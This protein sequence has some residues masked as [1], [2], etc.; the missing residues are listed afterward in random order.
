MSMAVRSPTSLPRRSGG[1][2][3]ARLPRTSIH[4]TK[5][6]R[7]RTAH[8]AGRDRQH[9]RSRRGRR[10]RKWP[11]LDRLT[12]PHNVITAAGAHGAHRNPHGADRHHSGRGRKGSREAAGGHTILATGGRSFTPAFRSKYSKIAGPPLDV[13]VARL[14]AARLSRLA[15]SMELTQ[16]LSAWQA[17]KRKYDAD[18]DVRENNAKDL[19]M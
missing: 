19:D 4:E 12:N 15:R 18:P 2:P 8:N 14:D 1:I 6:H 7:A 10:S 17:R 3:S 13:E 11:R 5:L 9:H 16:E